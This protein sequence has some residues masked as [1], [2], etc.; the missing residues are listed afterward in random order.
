MLKVLRSLTRLNF[1]LKWDVHIAQCRRGSSG[2]NRLLVALFGV[3]YACI[4]CAGQGLKLPNVL[5]E[6]HACVHSSNQVELQLLNYSLCLLPQCLE[7]TNGRGR[8]AFALNVL[9]ELR[10]QS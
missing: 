6:G 5:V 1:L 3:G 8:S 10:L 7:G 2:T 9:G 4:V